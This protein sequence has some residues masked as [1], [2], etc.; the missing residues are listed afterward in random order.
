MKD[1]FPVNLDDIQKQAVIYRSLLE[2]VL[3]FFPK[4]PAMISWGF[5][6]RYSW[7]PL[8]TNYTRGDSLPLDCQYQPKAAYWQ[9]QEVLARVLINGIYRLSPQSQPEKCLGTYNNGTNSSVQLYSGNC[10]NTN[11]KWNVT[12]LGDGTYRFSPQSA[13]N[14]A[15]HGY[16]TSATVGGVETNS[17]TGD[18]NQEWVITSQGNNTYLVGPRPAWWRVLAVDETSNV[19]IINYSMQ[20]S[21]QWILTNV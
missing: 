16:N 3:H 8:A 6:D 5:A 10:T 2:Y 18:F 19:I 17:W 9:L 7:I 12:W 11:E 4:I 1:G 14:S 21:Q 20:E 13:N 15:L